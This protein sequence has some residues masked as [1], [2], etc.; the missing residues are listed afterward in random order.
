MDHNQNPDT[1]NDELLTTE[2][3]AKLLG[4]AP[5]TLEVSRTTKRYPI[6]YLKIGRNVR[7]KK[8]A[9][10]HFRDSCVVAA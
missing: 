6:P 8:S 5:G 3:A 1:G 9:V 7:Y 10:L 2:G 4:L